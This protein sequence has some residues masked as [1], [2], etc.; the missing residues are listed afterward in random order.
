MVQGTTS[1]KPSQPHWDWSEK[2]AYE[3]SSAEKTNGFFSIISSIFSWLGSLF[4]CGSKNDV[5]ISDHNVS[6]TT[7]PVADTVKRA[8]RQ[9]QLDATR[10]GSGTTTTTAPTIIGGAKRATSFTN[11]IK[12]LLVQ[13][14]DHLE[15]RNSVTRN[16]AIDAL[17]TLKVL[18]PQL[19]EKHPK[20]AKSI[21]ILTELKPGIPRLAGEKK[22]VA[23]SLTELT[24]STTRTQRT[25][26]ARRAAPVRKPPSA[27]NQMTKSEL[28]TL[29]HQ[30]SMN[31]SAPPPIAAINELARR[32]RAAAN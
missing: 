13:I 24:T 16:Q 2:A 3:T 17:E 11:N 21:E 27:V 32:R 8:V 25:P 28:E 22:V 15:E 5:N 29:V 23:S 1:M 18:V 7:P 14:L 12:P 10:K 9:P 4:C 20:K 19:P 31:P 6:R 26:V 30:S